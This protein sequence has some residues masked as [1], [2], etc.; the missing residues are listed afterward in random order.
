MEATLYEEQ[1]KDRPNGVNNLKKRMSLDFA[2]PKNFK[3]PKLNS[4]LTSP[5]E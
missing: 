4:V 1:Y 5:G 3:R 2:N